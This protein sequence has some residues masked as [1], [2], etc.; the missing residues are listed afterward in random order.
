M[1]NA[2]VICYFFS[3]LSFGIGY[4]KMLVFENAISKRI[5]TYNYTID[6]SL[7]TSYFVL[8]IFLSVIGFVLFYFINEHKKSFKLSKNPRNTD[9]YGTIRVTNGMNT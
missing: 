7:A 5:N 6:L 4:S 3:L 9:A 8:S 1:R 2:A